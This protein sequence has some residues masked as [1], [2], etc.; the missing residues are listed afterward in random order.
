MRRVWIAA[1]AVLAISLVGWVVHA[2]TSARHADAEAEAGAGAASSKAD[3]AS[4]PVTVQVTTVAQKDV[5][6]E[7]DAL[8]TVTPLAS[9]NI[10]SLV[11][12]RLQ[13]VFFQESKPVHAGDP[14]A[15]IDPRPFQ[16]Q[17]HL[18]Q[19]ALAKDSALEKDAKLN[20][21]RDQE[22]VAKNL[23]AKQAVDDQQALHDEYA[24]A[25]QAD[26]AQVD[27]ASLQ[28]EYAHLVAPIDGVPGIRLVDPGNVVHASDANGIVVL[29]QL[30]PIAVILTLP[31]DDLPEVSKQM[32]DGALPVE[33]LSRDGTADLGKG[34]ASIIDNQIN[35]STATMR[36]K[37][38]FDNPQHALW[39]NQFVK[40]KLTVETR[41]GAIVVPSAA[42]QRGPQ[43]TYVYAVD[44]TTETVSA[45]PVTVDL[46][47]G[48]QSILKT[49]PKAG[50]QI[51]LE[52]QQ[53]LRP[54]SKIVVKNADENGTGSDV[55][56]HPKHGARPAASP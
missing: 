47:Q 7:L 27:Q 35:G 32:A 14:L 2:R 16:I 42:V 1:G 28:I 20:L 34:S 45:E 17:L 18:A 50:T 24:A 41:K 10:R 46:A 48:D 21:E 43:G 33:A 55:G 4:T 26:Q 56:D 37:A 39:P 40:A 22:L 6:I 51:V 54:G 29:T 31:E 3:A 36:L 5:P 49:G 9:V 52:G 11:D 13:K 15:Q 19:A 44:P 53:Q 23:I 8:G 12:G 25:M 38:V 30:D